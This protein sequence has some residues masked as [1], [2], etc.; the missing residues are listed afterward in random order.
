M[1]R[2][3]GVWRWTIA[4]AIRPSFTLSYS[5]VVVSPKSLL[6]S[7]LTLVRETCDENLSK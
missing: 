2:R 3:P 6:N 7:C 4:L 1:R 5:I